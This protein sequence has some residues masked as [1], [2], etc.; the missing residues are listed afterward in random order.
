MLPVF[1]HIPK[2]AGTY[3][4]NRL[5]ATCAT[6]GRFDSGKLKIN[7]IKTCNILK[8]NQ[9]TYRIIVQD[10]NDYCNNCGLF[11][12]VP[13]DEY[14]FRVRF[15]DWI[16]EKQNFKIQALCVTGNGFSS[17]EEEKE[18]ILNS[19]QDL[20]KFICLRDPYER[21]LS[22][23]SY[24]KSSQSEHESTHGIFGEMSFED[25]LNSEYLED[26]WLI[27]V[28]NNI[29]NDSQITDDDLYK[30]I[31]ILSTMHVFDMSKIDSSLF[32]IFKKC[33]NFDIEKDACQDIFDNLCKNKTKNKINVPFLSIKQ[34]TR[35]KFLQTTSLDRGLYNHFK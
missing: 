16:K 6:I 12:M 8:N 13:G 33:Y 17:F 34:E 30:S 35:R 31:N 7:S 5:F 24:L 4:F 11:Q 15:V 10:L 19:E 18:L 9:V 28:L 21:C 2:N 25:Y 14:S 29:P 32:N 27:R 20:Y 26:S 3:I 1:F 22:L 23:F